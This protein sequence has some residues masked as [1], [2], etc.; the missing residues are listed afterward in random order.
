MFHLF[1]FTKRYL[2]HPVATSSHFPTVVIISLNTRNEDNYYF[3]TYPDVTLLSYK[4]RG[5]LEWNIPV[6]E[7]TNSALP[8][9][10]K[11]PTAQLLFWV[12]V[13]QNNS[14][15]RNQRGSWLKKRTCINQVCSH[16]AQFLSNSSFKRRFCFALFFRE[17][18]MDERC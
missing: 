2:T 14:L 16:G 4:T 17:Q 5:I 13:L 15:D 10:R 12:R 18:C 8:P 3:G 9:F 1:S 11:P 6:E 7:I